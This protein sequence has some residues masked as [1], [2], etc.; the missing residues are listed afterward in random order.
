MLICS[1]ERSRVLANNYLILLFDV[2]ALCSILL[3]RLEYQRVSLAF[4]P[5]ASQW[6]LGSTNAQLLLIIETN[7]GGHSA[8]ASFA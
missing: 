3:H 8:R 4:P 7:N 2:P 6:L 1:F 5:L